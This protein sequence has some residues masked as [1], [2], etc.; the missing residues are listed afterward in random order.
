MTGA[1]VFIDK[2]PPSPIRSLCDVTQ[3]E[4]FTDEEALQR[5]TSHPPTSFL[6]LFPDS[7][8]PQL[9]APGD[10]NETLSVFKSAQHEINKALMQYWVRKAGQKSPRGCRVKLPQHCVRAKLTQHEFTL[11]QCGFFFFLSVTLPDRASQLVW[12]HDYHFTISSP[13]SS[14]FCVSR[15]KNSSSVKGRLHLLLNN[16]Y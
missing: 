16:C 12:F 13:V 11:T 1:V 5:F 4:M 15:E 10:Q 9:L 6:A 8:P 2:Q 3:V 14:F 7:L